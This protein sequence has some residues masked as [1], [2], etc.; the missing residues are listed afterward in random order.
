MKWDT[1]LYHNNHAFV[2]EYGEDLIDLLNPQKGERILDLGCGLGQL[3]AK[4]GKSCKEVVGI[5]LSSDMIQAAK[6]K[7]KHIKF[8]Q[9]DAANFQFAKKFDV[10]FSNATLHWVADYKSAITSM[11]N[12]LEKGGKIVVEFG[13]KGNVK[14]IIDALR[15]ALIKRGYHEQGAL[16]QWY[17]PSIAA[18]AKVLEEHGFKVIFAQHFER[19]TELAG[20]DTGIQDWLAM[21]AVNFFKGV[22]TEDVTAIQQEVQ[23]QL[24]AS[25]L[26]NNKWYAD[27][28]RIR[29]IAIKQ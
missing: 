21:F 16:N 8:E 12:N 28:Q 5:D 26:K 6:K 7:Y 13:A 24:R 2:Y 3:T 23:E 4:I 29:V 20:Q 11:H 22:A 25:S 9:A 19:P 18:Y 1:T 15:D 27:Y 14:K 17:F 10:I